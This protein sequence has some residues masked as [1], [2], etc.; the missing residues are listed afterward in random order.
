MFHCRSLSGRCLASIAVCLAVLFLISVGSIRH[1]S[2]QPLY[3][4]TVLTPPSG[5]SPSEVNSLNAQ[6]MACGA[7]KDSFGAKRPVTWGNVTHE[8]AVLP[9]LPAPYD[10]YAVARGITDSGVVVGDS[11]TSSPVGSLKTYPSRGFIYKGNAIT[12]LPPAEAFPYSDGYKANTGDIV[13]GTSYTVDGNGEILPTPTVWSSDTPKA[14][15]KLG[16]PYGVA[17]DIND[18]GTIV[19]GCGLIVFGSFKGVPA[20]LA[21]FH[22]TQWI[23]GTG[24]MLPDL[25]G[26]AYSSAHGINDSGEVVGVSHNGTTVY[27]EAIGQATKWIDGTPSAVPS[28]PNLPLSTAVAVNNNGEIVG[29]AETGNYT[30]QTGY[31]NIAGTTYDL[32]DSLDVAGYTV[33]APTSI[34]SNGQITATGNAWADP[35]ATLT[36]LLTPVPPALKDAASSPSSVVSGTSAA[37]TVTLTSSA[38]ASG[39]LVGLSSSDA[40]VASVPASALVLFGQTSK[41]VAISTL[42]VSAKTTVTFTASYAGTH[43]TCTLT[44]TPATLLSVSTSPATVVGGGSSTGTVKL[45]GFAPPKG[46]SVTITSSSTDVVPQSPVLV[47]SGKTSAT[48]SIATKKVTSTTPV[49]LTATYADVKQTTVLTLKQ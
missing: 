34:N 35:S 32:N 48:F 9:L 38:P 23:N 31:V 30:G 17:Q 1:A 22:A 12:E 19:G 39:V 26:Y 5:T 46:A 44:V 13:V 47:A 45:T 21:E 20:E 8:P 36:L 4:V 27:G 42:G 24:S 29:Y 15:P 11:G 2:A 37:L 7:V 25:T 41:T 16:Q 28:L 40:A 33:V 43:K 3:S 49:T 18:N 14:L 6:G 10:S